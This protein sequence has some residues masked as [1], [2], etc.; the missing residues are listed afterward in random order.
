MIIFFIDSLKKALKFYRFYYY[1]IVLKSINGPA[2]FYRGFRKLK[3]FLAPASILL[4]SLVSLSTVGLDVWALEVSLMLTEGS[5]ESFW[6]LVVKEKLFLFVCSSLV[7]SGIVWN[8][9][10]VKFRLLGFY[11]LA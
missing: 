6:T 8:D 3:G 11:A 7:W 9:G 10:V 2:T 4:L 5:S 1:L